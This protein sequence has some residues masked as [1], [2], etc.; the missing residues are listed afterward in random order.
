MPPPSGVKLRDSCRAC[1]ASKVRCS[2]DKPTCVRC[3]DRGTHCQYL[4]TQR[5][6]RKARS[7]SNETS[8][9]TTASTLP[10]SPSPTFETIMGRS[11]ID[12]PH[13]TLDSSV[14]DFIASL[15]MSPSFGIPGICTSGVVGPPFTTPEY[16]YDSQAGS[17]LSQNDV[18]LQSWEDS[19]SAFAISESI[20]KQSQINDADCLKTALQLMAQ[21]SCSDYTL[22][23]SPASIGSECSWK[24]HPLSQMII[25][26][27]KEIIDT[28]GTIL[29]S[30]C[31]QDG[32]FLFIISMIVS[33]VLSAY[34]TS[35]CSSYSESDTRSATA[36][37]SSSSRRS[38]TGSERSI[39]SSEKAEGMDPKTVQQVLNE[40]YQVEGLINKLSSRIQQCAKDNRKF[41]SKPSNSDDDA[42]YAASP[43][44][45]TVLNQVD[46]E[47]RERLSNLSL[48]LIEGLRQYWK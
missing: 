44:S 26:T 37:P 46:T 35:A 30:T 25:S 33:R 36:S 23:A 1:A 5:T 11:V 20:H 15:S 34:A 12:S 40:L 22:C 39:G 4:V 10:T 24:R 2:K 47:L 16:T 48:E 42:T 18:P 14:D 45:A 28:V 41:G 9:H 38:T 31:S 13:M 6:G 17:T 29:T 43:F 32:Y 21:L 27:N 7:R 8:S 3:A 19:M